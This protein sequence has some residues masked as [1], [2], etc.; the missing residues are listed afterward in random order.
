MNSFLEGDLGKPEKLYGDDDAEAEFQ[1]EVE[2][3][4]EFKNLHNEVAN[5]IKNNQFTLQSFVPS[6]DES[7]KVNWK[8]AI[9][10][11]LNNNLENFEMDSKNQLLLKQCY[12]SLDIFS[13]V[14]QKQ[15]ELTQLI[16]TVVP[17]LETQY[18]E[19]QVQKLQLQIYPGCSNRMMLRMANESEMGLNFFMMCFIFIEN[20]LIEKGVKIEIPPIEP[21]KN[22]N[23]CLIC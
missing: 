19:I 13:F 2:K 22:K 21:P 1:K 11:F 3:S 9:L 8:E 16:I 10:T 5:D 7:E 20:I 14:E 17:K 4:L 18:Q 23:N 12:E 15:S 6:D